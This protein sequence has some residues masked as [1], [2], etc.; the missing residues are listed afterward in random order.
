[1]FPL[2]SARRFSCGAR[3]VGGCFAGT[4]PAHLPE[5]RRNWG[6]GG[7]RGP[8][9]RAFL[10]GPGAGPS[11]PPDIVTAVEKKNRLLFNC[12]KLHRQHRGFTRQRLCRCLKIGI[13]RFSAVPAIQRAED[14]LS[15]FIASVQISG[16]GVGQG[17]GP[18][19]PLAAMMKAAIKGFP[20]AEICGQIASST[21]KSG[22]RR[23]A[24]AAH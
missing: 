19:G 7:H 1:M 21:G 17:A 23:P 2:F 15:L 24:H 13:C 6:M 14:A 9:L 20:Q 3:P 18:G 12:G 8:P 4:V 10:Q 16:K 5:A 22:E 11:P